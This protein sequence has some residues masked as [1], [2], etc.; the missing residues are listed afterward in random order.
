MPIVTA[1]TL[2]ALGAASVAG[3]AAY[4]NK[5]NTRRNSQQSISDTTPSAYARRQSGSMQGDG[6]DPSKQVKRKL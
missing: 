5:S 3:A 2:F 1:G 4:K 6:Y